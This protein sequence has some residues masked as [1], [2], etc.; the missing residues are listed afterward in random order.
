MA[1]NSTIHRP[2]RFRDHDVPKPL[3]TSS[4]RRPRARVCIRQPGPP[5]QR[6]DSLPSPDRC[7]PGP[8]RIA[9]KQR[10]QPSLDPFLILWQKQYRYFAC[11]RTPLR[12]PAYPG[13]YW[14]HELNR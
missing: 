4:P 13:L 9:R 11:G 8:G 6:R 14:S 12:A 2:L 7:P 5:G 3:C 10:R 1:T